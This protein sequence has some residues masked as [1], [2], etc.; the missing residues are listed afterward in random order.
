MA[1]TIGNSYDI[2]MSIK[3]EIKI[4]MESEVKWMDMIHPFKLKRLRFNQ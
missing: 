4:E 3:M 1:S 2:L